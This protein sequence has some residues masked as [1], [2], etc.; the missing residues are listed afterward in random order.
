MKKIFLLLAIV[1]FFGCKS[2]Q[3]IQTNTSESSS[4]EKVKI[5]S[6]VSEKI[7]DNTV[8][9]NC[10]SSETI[11]RVFDTSKPIDSVTKVPPLIYEKVIRKKSLKTQKN[12]IKKDVDL[13]LKKDVKLDSNNYKKTTTKE[14]YNDKGFVYYVGRFTLIVVFLG[15]LFL[16]LRFFK[17]IR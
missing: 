17:V 8:F 13:H 5:D 2:K 10:D 14:T 15:I 16:L 9:E 4:V 3:I 11:I 12:D 1:I 7:N 6:I